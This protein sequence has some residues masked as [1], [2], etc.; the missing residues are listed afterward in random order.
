MRATRPIKWCLVGV[1]GNFVLVPHRMSLFFNG[2]W[3]STCFPQMPL[4]WGIWPPFDTFSPGPNTS[5]QPKR[6]LDRFG[7]FC[8]ALSRDH[9]PISRH[10]DHA[11]SSTPC[12]RYGPLAGVRSAWC[13]CVQTVSRLERSTLATTSTTACANWNSTR[14]SSN[15]YNCRCLCARS[16]TC[17]QTLLNQAYWA[18]ASL[19]LS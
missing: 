12:A 6:H 4:H 15:R 17:D 10:T 5:P 2:R 16:A 18:R 14:T 11:V 3:V 19:S 1:W 7:R 8:R 13:G 9:W